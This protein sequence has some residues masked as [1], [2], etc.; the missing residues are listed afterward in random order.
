MNLMKLDTCR[1]LHMCDYRHQ[2]PDFVHVS[3]C[4][5]ASLKNP[6]AVI[7]ASIIPSGTKKATTEEVDLIP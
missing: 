7:C 3:E 6:G 1:D 4:R 2:H 5:S